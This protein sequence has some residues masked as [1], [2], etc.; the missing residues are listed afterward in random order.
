MVGDRLMYATSNRHEGLWHIEVNDVNGKT[1]RSSATSFADRV[2]FA[3]TDAKGTIRTAEQI[4]DYTVPAPQLLEA[5]S[6]QTIW[7][8]SI[9][10]EQIVFWSRHEF[11]A[12]DFE[13]SWGFRGRA[14]IYIDNSIFHLPVPA[15]M[16]P[17]IRCDGTWID[18]KPNTQRAGCP[19]GLRWGDGSASVE[20]DLGISGSAPLEM[21][22][23]CAA[24]PTAP[25]FPGGE[26]SFCPHPLWSLR[27]EAVHA[28]EMA[29]NAIVRPRIAP[30]PAEE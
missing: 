17:Q 24:I 2:F 10:P 15:A 27:I 12:G 28:H 4:A 21:A 11:R 5:R 8:K 30:Q 18:L 6:C 23:S 29:L 22:T 3:A 13:F 1:H 14:G 9:E 19:S 26:N 7:R 16:H 20:I 25:G